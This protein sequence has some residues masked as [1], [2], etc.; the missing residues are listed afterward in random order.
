MP[1]L[2]LGSVDAS[3]FNSTKYPGVCKPSNTATLQTFKTL[4]AQL[5]RL[6]EG[7]S[8]TKITVD[9]DI[10]A[11]TVGLL[12]SVK[13]VLGQGGVSVDPARNILI[14][15]D[16]SSC[17]AV[18]SNADLLGDAAKGVADQMG[19]SSTI[20][21]PKPPGGSS[22]LVSASGLESRV[23]TGT[24]ASN[25]IADMIGLGGVDT[26]TL[27]LLAAGLGAAVYFTG[28]KGKKS[29]SARHTTSRRRR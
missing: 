19:V 17:T 11:G 13:S 23:T 5:N 6:A 28:P 15:A 21:Q 8:L 4:Q 22:T 2:Q 18:A 29:A 9:G 12:S 26:T 7:L 10:G 1:Y 16:A 24:P 25:G 14:Q 27:V 3:N 20:S